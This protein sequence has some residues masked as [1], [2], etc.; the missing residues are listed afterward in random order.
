MLITSSGIVQ[1][2]MKLRDARQATLAY[3]YFDFRDKEKQNIRNFITS[4]LLQ[5]SGC[6][7]HYY[8]IISG[9][10]S[11]HGNG[12]RRP[13]HGALMGC[14]KEM[15]T[16][17]VEL[18]VFVII[19]ALDECFDTPG[20]QTP[21]EGILDV[22]KELTQL[23]HPN[24]HICVTSRQEVDV[25]TKLEPLAV[26]AVSLHEQSGRKKDIANY[27]S[28]VMSLDENLKKWR[29]E[30]KNLVVEELSERADGM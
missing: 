17:A 8:E 22:V 3:Y 29:D 6:S 1:H 7:N 11:S 12:M 19:E 20:I 10:Y 9:L 4:M 14:L 28:Y 5:L 16:V 2:V 18:P 26:S 24:L 13:S 21:Q 15:L 25:Q 23:R 27:V 30:D